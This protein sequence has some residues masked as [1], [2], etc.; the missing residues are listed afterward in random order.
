MLVLD[1]VAEESGCDK[2]LLKR[3][4]RNTFQP[5]RNNLYMKDKVFNIVHMTKQNIEDSS[6][7]RI[8][9]V[10]RGRVLKCKCNEINSIISEYIM[11]IRPYIK[12]AILSSLIKEAEY[13]INIDSLC[14]YDN[15]FVELSEYFE[16]AKKIR[17]ISIISRKTNEIEAFI[18]KCYCKLGVK[19]DSSEGYINLYRAKL[20]LNEII[21]NKS[22]FLNVDGYNMLIYADEAYFSVDEY[23]SQLLKYETPIEYI[24]ASLNM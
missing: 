6:V 11:D 16:L 7:K 19:I 21:M 12:R 14:I 5:E 24:C 1:I 3:M 10:N 17:K 15:D 22:A 23:S 2:R 20:D 13:N 8:L 18:Q 4:K 9:E